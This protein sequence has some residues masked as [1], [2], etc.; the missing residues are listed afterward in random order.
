[1]SECI[2]ACRS[3]GMTKADLELL[4]RNLA[5]TYADGE[6]VNTS[7]DRQL[8]RRAE[9]YG[10]VHKL[11]ELIFP[12]FDGE[13]EFFAGSAEFFAGALLSELYVEL[14]DQVRRS[15][16]GRMMADDCANCPIDERTQEAVLA[17]L[18]ALP[19][20][21]RIMKEDVAAAYAGDPAASSGA[22]IILSYPGIKAITIQRLAHVLYRHRVPM[23]PRLMTEYAHGLTG[24][25]IHP[26]AQL[27]R[28]IFIDHGTG[29]VIGETVVLGDGARL[30]QGV[31]LG[32]LNFPKDA[33][34]ML[35]KGKKRHPTIGERVIIYAGASVLGD[36]EIGRDSVIGGNV[37]I[38]ESLP[39]GSK[40]SMTAPE[41][42]IRL[43]KP[44]SGK[45]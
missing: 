29:V 45:P 4:T 3:D 40:V 5:A 22:E 43:A 6:G 2:G 9:V 44:E 13:R 16:R 41:Q 12:G 11:L 30:Y 39:P 14:S 8:P 15:L 17:L 25:D 24:I 21:R 32:A 37:W 1:M 20:V 36:I 42:R 31:T 18:A 35:V 27:G 33:C 19:E 34:G 38:T 10:I 7:D 28:G 23:L 26:G